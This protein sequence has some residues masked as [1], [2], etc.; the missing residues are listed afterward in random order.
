MQEGIATILSGL[1]L[2]HIMVSY[3]SSYNQDLD[4]VK[5]YYL[6]GVACL[7]ALLFHS[8]LNRSVVGDF[9]W[10]FTQYLETFA[11]LSQFVLFRNK[12]IMIVGRKA[13][14]SRI[15]LISWRRRQYLECC[16]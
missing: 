10:A 9:T 14:L 8:S 13:I 3:K 15:H 12:V 1:I 5:S 7:L 16:S 6:I 4:T 2:Y 11:I